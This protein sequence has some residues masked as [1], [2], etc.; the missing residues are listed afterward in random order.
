MDHDVAVVQVGDHGSRAAEQLGE[1]VVAGRHAERIAVDIRY[2]PD[3]CPGRGG[4]HSIIMAPAPREV[5]ALVAGLS[6]R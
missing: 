6:S 3:I 4:T 1:G 5:K 2:Q